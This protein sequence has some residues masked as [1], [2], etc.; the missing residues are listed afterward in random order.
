MLITMIKSR[1]QYWGIICAISLI[2][3]FSAYIFVFF[4]S[5]YASLYFAYDFDIP[6]FFSLKGINFYDQNPLSW[7]RDAFITIFLSIPL[8]GLIIGILSLL[9]LIINIKKP[10]AIILFLLWIIIFAFTN[11]LG[12]LINDAVWQ[13]GT[14]E[15]A[16]I[17]NMNNIIIL[18]MAVLYAFVLFKIGIMTGKIITLSFEYLNL[19]LLKNKL[20]FL[21]LILILPWLITVFASCIL[22]QRSFAWSLFFIN[23]PVLLLIIPTMAGKKPWNKEIGYKPQSG[24]ISLDI[25]LTIS[26]FTLSAIFIMLMQNGISITR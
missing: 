1:N 18:L 3:A 6:A 21:L 11:S 24:I 17:M 23:I 26:V 8:T 15:V 25:I 19:N 20:L 5:N 4:I 9:L 13:T 22:T 12:I 2:T 14:Y 16:R 7:S 10:I